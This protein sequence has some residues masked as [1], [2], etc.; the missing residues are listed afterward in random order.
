MSHKILILTTLLLTLGCNSYKSKLS[1]QE[2]NVMPESIDYAFVNAKVFQPYC[3]RCHSTAGGNEGDVNLE[4]YA[5]VLENIDAVR[6]EA[7]EKREMPPKKAGGALSEFPHEVLRLWI[8]AGAPVSGQTHKPEASPTP[9]PTPETN[10]PANPP[11]EPAPGPVE[12]PVLPTWDD[13]YTKILSKKCIECHQAGKKA[14]DVPFTDRNYV[15]DPQ[16]DIVTPGNPEQSTIIHALTREDKKRMPPPPPKS[17]YT[18]SPQEI[19]AI[20]T[21]I[22][23]GAKD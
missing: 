21:W 13:I 10:P 16:N 7:V 11:V 2:T 20:K 19:E 15:I 18:V 9:S 12:E 5:S 3:I 23:N 22:K 4:T 1:D 8:D 17:N 14:E 6:E